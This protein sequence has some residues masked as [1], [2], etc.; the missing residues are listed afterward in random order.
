MQEA[1]KVKEGI[2]KSFLLLIPLVIALAIASY[3][4]IAPRRSTYTLTSAWY[5]PEEIKDKKL[6]ITP[7]GV[8][9]VI[10]S[11]TL[12]DGRLSYTI[13]AV[14]DGKAQAVLALGESGE[15]WFLEVR[16][17]ALFEGGIN[18]G[19]WQAI[20]A[21]TCVFFAALVALFARGLWKLWR[22]SWYGYTMVGCG[23]CLLFCFF[24]FAFFLMLLRSGVTP[25]FSTFLMDLIY[26]AEWFAA[27]MMVLMFPLILAI[28]V[29]NVA[30]VRHEG[31]RPV[32]ILGILASVAWVLGFLAWAL[33]DWDWLIDY[34]M[35]VRFA[36]TA[37]GMAVTFGECL[38]LSTMLCAWLA[39][40]HVPKHGVDY[41][42]TLGCGIRDDG[43]PCP[44]LAGRVDRAAAFDQERVAAGDA[45]AT[46]VPSGGQGS[47]E[48]ISEALSMGNYLQE[49]WDVPEERIVLEDRSTT[50]RENMAFSREVIERHAGRSVDELSVGFSTT[51]YH[52]FRGYVAAHQAG[53]A[54]EGMGA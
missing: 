37:I 4:Y 19:G 9:K 11:R 45:P 16:D 48:P 33:Y 43:T 22:I 13:E 26:M 2:W 20:Q 35:V 6:I 28:G 36:N 27:S 38:L 5:T 8:V 49:H 14:S 40:R 46:F 15:S 10:S 24:Q 53:M 50:T 12:P 29:S 34:P 7:P 47:D 1:N 54:V 41:L 44:L 17:G 39:S 42:V 30:L 23:G 18:F 21:S 31:M 25:S 51:N 32:N 3:A 52:V